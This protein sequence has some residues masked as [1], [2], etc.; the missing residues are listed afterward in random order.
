MRVLYAYTSF[1]TKKVA[2]C[3]PNIRNTLLG[4]LARRNFQGIFAEPQK[5]LPAKISPNKVHYIGFSM[6]N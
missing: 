1:D 6:N 5:F 3:I 2:Q 4:A